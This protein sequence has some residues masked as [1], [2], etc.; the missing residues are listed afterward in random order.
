LDSAQ[1]TYRPSDST[2]SYQGSD[3]LRTLIQLCIGKDR[4]AQKQLYEK[5]SPWL[6]GMI[7]R[8]VFSADTAQEILN[9][10]FFK[11]LTRL[12]S[13][14]FT[15][16][17][18]G[19]A[20][21]IAINTITDYIRKNIKREQAS[22]ALPDEYNIPVPETT[23]GKMSYKELLELV[24]ALPEVQRSVFNLYV[25]EQFSHKEIGAA[26]D[27]TENNSRWHLND[28]RRRLKEKLDSIM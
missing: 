7:R 1:E 16:P 20:R 9:D 18:E 10:S 11:I 8:Y 15:G 22:V 4:R 24:H 5:F 14:S 26:L 6:Y 19:W 28:A 27:I 12:D 17:F 23:I 21:R 3:E 2:G 13:Y 25:F